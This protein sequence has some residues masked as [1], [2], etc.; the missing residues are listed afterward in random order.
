M[1][2]PPEISGRI[3]QHGRRRGV[4]RA[5]QRVRLGA[6]HVALFA[7]RR[8]NHRHPNDAALARELLKTLHVSA[9]VVLAGVGA[10][11]IGPFQHHGLAAKVGQPADLALAVG[12]AEIG[13]RAAYLGLARRRLARS[14]RRGRAGGPCREASRADPA[15]CGR[16][17]AGAQ[18]KDEGSRDMRY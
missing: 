13:C 9:G 7:G 16:R 10:V 18:A 14:R 3:E 8:G 11:R 1:I 4:A 2:E 12:R 5:A 6:A 15:A 17:P